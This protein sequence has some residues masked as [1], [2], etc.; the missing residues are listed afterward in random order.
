M[1]KPWPRPPSRLSRGT[2]RV[3]D[4]DLRMGAA[5]LQ[6]KLGVGLHGL[7]VAQNLVARVRQFDQEGAVALVAGRVGVGLGHDQRDVRHAGGRAEPFLA[8]QD[9][10]IAVERGAGLHARRVG[11][12]RLLGHGVANSLLAVQ[13]RLEEALLLIVRAVFEQ[14]QHGG[15]VRPLGVQ[16]QGAQEALAKLHLHQARWPRAAAPCRRAPQARRGTTSLGCGP[17]CATRPAPR[18]SCRRCIVPQPDGIPAARTR[19][20]CCARPWCP[21]VFQSRSCWVR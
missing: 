5:Q 12:R 8:V 14:G 2:R 10:L 6:A 3:L 13:Q 20:P 19:A 18:R 16:R 11:A 7:D 15:V 21:R 4:L 1:L 17:C 9:P